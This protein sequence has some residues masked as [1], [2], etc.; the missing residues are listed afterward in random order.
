[1]VRHCKTV[2]ILTIALATALLS[3]GDRLV[4]QDIGRYGQVGAAPRYDDRGGGQPDP[5]GAELQPIEAGQIIARISDQVVLAGDVLPQV[6][7]IL[8]KYADQI[9]PGQLE[10]ASRQLMQRQLSELIETKILYAEFNRTIPAENLPKIEESL[11]KEFERSELPKLMELNKA[12]NRAELE[13]KL[14]EKGSSLNHERRMFHER[15]IASQWLNQQIDRDVEITHQQLLADYREHLEDYK[16]E[17]KARWEEISVRF[18]RFANKQEAYA[19]LC[20]LGDQVLLRGAPFGEVAR[21]S[22]HGLTATEG[23]QHDW[24]TQGSLVSTAIDKAIFTLP[25][26]QLSQIIED[27]DSFHIIRV[28]ERKWAGATP[29]VEAQEKIRERLRQEGNRSQYSDYLVT[30]RSK[31]RVWTIFDAGIGEDG[32]EQVGERTGNGPRR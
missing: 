30:L 29:F 1:M 12:T 32:V 23:G 4:G 15:T 27:R 22:S 17:S 24:T 16:F 13:T 20:A 9:P 7:S 5:N 6:N 8:K 31:H 11:S 25:V 14:R 10:A 3:H 26:G 2:A 18:D 28:V 19:A 21:S